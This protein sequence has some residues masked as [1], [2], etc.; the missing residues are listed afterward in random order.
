LLSCPSCLLCERPSPHGPHS[1]WAMALVP[2]CLVCCSGLKPVALAG[3]SQ[4]PGRQL[5]SRLH[6]WENARGGVYDQQNMGLS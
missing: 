1:H 2:Q 6:M 3:P 4:T 5:K